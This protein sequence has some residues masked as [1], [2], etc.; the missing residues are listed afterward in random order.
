[1]GDTY[2]VALSIGTMPTFGDNRRQVEAHLL[3]FDGD[4]YGQ[5]LRVEVTDWVR[6]QWK[7]NGVEPLKTQMARDI[8]YCA[9]RRLDAGGRRD[10][11]AV[12]SRVVTFASE[13]SRDRATR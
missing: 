2:P 12:R 9:E 11:D 5:P 8:D 3:G 13:Q 1:M 10:A 7:F 6:D 4:L